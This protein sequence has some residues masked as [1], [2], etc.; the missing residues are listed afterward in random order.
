MG[1]GWRRDTVSWRSD[2]HQGGAARPLPP[3]RAIPTTPTH[4]PPPPYWNPA[5]PLQIAH[6][7]RV[8]ALALKRL[9]RA[10]QAVQRLAVKAR[11]AVERLGVGGV[12]VLHVRDEAEARERRGRALRLL[13][14]SAREGG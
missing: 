11:L 10:R 3:A 1:G 2:C 5:P 13:W 7:H 14:R 6:Q 4:G 8:D 12:G 9:E